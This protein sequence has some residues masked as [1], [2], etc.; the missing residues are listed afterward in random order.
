M[1]SLV[2]NRGLAAA[3]VATLALG[4]AANTLVFSVVYAALFRP[5]PYPSSERLVR[6]WESRPSRGWS[7]FGVSTPALRDWRAAASFSD[8]AGFA[9]STANF[10][11]G[12]LPER[13]RVTRASASLLPLLGVPPVLGR[14]FAEEEE[15]PGRDDVVV[16]SDGFWRRAFGGDPGVLGRR[17]LLDGAPV[18]VVG[19]MPSRFAFPDAEVDVW[20]PLVL[21]P[22]DDRRG[23]RWLE[24]VARLAQGVSP[25]QAR[26]EMDALAQ[27]NARDHPRTSAGWSIDVVALQDARAASERPVLVMLWCAVGLVLIVACANLAHL[28]LARSAGRAGEIAVRVALG[29]SPAR[30]TRQV[31]TESAVLAFAGGA[32]GVLVAAAGLSLLGRFAAQAPLGLIDAR[33]NAAV[34]GFAAALSILAGL[35]SGT[36][37]ARHALRSSVAE[38]LRGSG[39][40]VSPRRLRRT[41]IVGEVGLAVVLLVGSGLLVRSLAG[42]LALDPGFEPAGLLT[43][44]VAPPQSPPRP[45]QSEEEFLNG[46]LRERDGAAAFY[47]ALSERLRALPGVPDAGAVNRM[48][49]T[50]R[51]WMVGVTIEGQP[52]PAP[53]EEP[54]VRGRVVTPGW[55]RA[56]RVPL[57]RGRDLT[58]RDSGAAP[59]VA[60]VSESLAARF[61]PGESALGRRL[62][63]GDPG[64]DGWVT[65]V[66]VVADVRGDLAEPSPEPTAYVPLAQ[67]RF[68]LFPDWGMDVAVRTQGDPLALAAAVRAVVHDLDPSLPVFAVRTMD[69]VL[70][71]SLAERRLAV[72]LLGLFAASALVLA[73]VGV[74]GVVARSVEERTREIG[75]RVALGADPARVVRLVVGEG[76]A[77]VVLGLGAGAALARGLTRLAASQ[78][79]GVGPGDPAT[80]AAA[81]AL[82]I[83]VASAACALPAIR[84]ARRDPLAALRQA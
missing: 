33:L 70:A 46:H 19:V 49:M 80:Y 30:I 55:F 15:Q 50:G 72:S 43:F 18:Q 66:G 59:M 4:I 42:L 31:L 6:V 78:L 82:V 48:P 14:A 21:G 54:N 1:R 28:L 23:A 56:M 2:R 41:L 3:A 32:A 61:W 69:G 25:D 67:S 26:A 37:P 27:R 51:W 74:A 58:E 57:V 47:A 62:A 22:E 73:A 81:G 9:R 10:A 75:V 52:R 76:L 34:L 36:A 84:A 8:V 45:G 11:G 63:F 53:G 77:P 5:L 60:I 16:L 17:V 64:R 65:V 13:V 71:A 12:G 38:P 79:Y 35:A 68:G 44:R 39:A 83:V 29:A 7:R 40:A 24:S 20:R